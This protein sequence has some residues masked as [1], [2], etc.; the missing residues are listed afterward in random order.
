MTTSTTSTTSTSLRKHPQLQSFFKEAESRF[1]RDEELEFYL[2][3][4]PEGENLAEASRE[5]KNVST[6]IAKK[7]VAG[8]YSVYP[9]EKHHEF[10]VAKCTRDVR[11][12]IAYG[13]LAMLM[14]DLTW[15]RNKLLL[16]MKTIVQSFGHPDLEEGK[17]PYHD[18]PEVV[19]HLKELKPHQR[20]IYETYYAVREEM[21]AN[22]TPD[23]YEAFAPYISEAL[24][25]LAHD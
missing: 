8:I 25:V 19:E 4:Y 17:R 20:S 16:W 9:Y 2:T 15:Y 10:A 7:V 14:N 11:Y 1:L 5:I 3:E 24:Q 12:V 23:S 18:I 13:T 22:L 6:Q 21:K